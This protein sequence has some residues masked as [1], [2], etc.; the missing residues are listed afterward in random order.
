MSVS[1]C[2]KWGTE[3]IS[4]YKVY[5]GP[6][7]WF[8]QVK[9]TVLAQTPPHPR[10]ACRHVPMCPGWSPSRCQTVVRRALDDPRILPPLLAV[11]PAAAEVVR[12][13]EETPCETSFS[14]AAAQRLPGELGE[15]REQGK[16][17]GRRR[18]ETPRRELEENRSEKR[19]GEEE[20]EDEGV[21]VEAG[22]THRQ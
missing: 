19:S 6:N 13:A 12:V 17:G 15:G 7:F 16:G 18:A 21:G 1:S 10:S 22:S 11:L 14:D 5:K 2:W 20:G 3:L 8:S 4:S 9:L